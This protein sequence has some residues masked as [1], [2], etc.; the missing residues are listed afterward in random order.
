MDFW[1]RPDGI[2]VKGSTFAV[3]NQGFRWF[4]SSS[5][6]R[7]RP[8]PVPCVA[9]G[10]WV[11]PQRPAVPLVAGHPTQI[12]KAPGMAPERAGPWGNEVRNR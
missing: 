5:S 9:H 10:S 11:E 7:S 3:N 4:R 6:L 12:P 2:M 8:T 1:G